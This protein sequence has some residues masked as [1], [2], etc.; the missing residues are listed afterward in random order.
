MT[1]KAKANILVVEDSLAAAKRLQFSLERAG[2]YVDVARDGPEA[3]EK[4]RQ[5]QYDLVV[6][7][8]QMPGMTGRELCKHLRDDDRYAH[9]PLIFLTGKLYELDSNELKNVLH[10]SAAF[11][12]PFTLDSLMR[13]IV[14]ELAAARSSNDLNSDRASRPDHVHAGTP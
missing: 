9:T 7:D 13:A 12:K 5:A 10:V 1:H 6:T 2:F 14:A 8:E 11:P 4:A 3:L